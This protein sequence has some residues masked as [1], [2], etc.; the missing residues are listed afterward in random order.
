VY[1]ELGMDPQSMMTAGLRLA[2]I[3]CVGWGHPVTSGLKSIDYWLSSDLMEPDNAQN[4]YSE[5]LVRLPN[6]ANS[7]SIE[8]RNYISKLKNKKSRRDYGLPEDSILYFCSQ[9]LF[10]Y[11]PQYDHLWP[12][13]AKRVPGCKFVFLAISSVHV[14]RSFMKRVEIEFDKHGLDAKEYCIMLNRQQPDDY[15]ILN[16][17]M[18]VFLD[19]PPWSGNNTSM[20]AVDACLPVVS[21]PTEFMRGRHTF[22]ILKMLNIEETIASTEKDYV[23]ISVK[24]GLC[25]KYRKSIKYKISN[26]QEL[27][28]DDIDC[29]R[30]LEE[31]YIKVVQ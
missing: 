11:L 19:N 12:E 7:Y 26:N 15:L 8:N 22:G 3:Q 14:V 25:D 1:P 23:E 16:T 17:L 29:V 27:I 24:L 2:P 30:G 18:D 10:K 13:I 9:S 6:L 28:Y 21:M 20:A 31:F 5:K 4:H